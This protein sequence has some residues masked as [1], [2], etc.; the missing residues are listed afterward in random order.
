VCFAKSGVEL[1]SYEAS[2]VA[3][4]GEARQRAAELLRGAAAVRETKLAVEERNKLLRAMARGLG[5]TYGVA[6]VDLEAI[7]GE[8][9]GLMGRLVQ[10]EATLEQQKARGSGWVGACAQPCCLQNARTHAQ[11][12]QLCLHTQPQSADPAP[13][14]PSS[15]PSFTLPTLPTLQTTLAMQV[16]AS[17]AQ[18]Q[19]RI[20]AFEAR[21][22][23]AKPRGTPAGSAD[24]LMRQFEELQAQLAA[25]LS[26][27][28]FL[29]PI[30]CTSPRSARCAERSHDRPVRGCRHAIHA[31]SRTQSLRASLALLNHPPPSRVRLSSNHSVTRAQAE[32]TKREAAMFELPAPDFGLLDALQ[33]ELAATVAAWGLYRSFS[34]ERDALAGALWDAMR[35]Q[36]HRV[37]DFIA[38]WGRAC[39]QADGAD[40]ALK[41]TL[42]KELHSYKRCERVLAA[43]KGCA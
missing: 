15:H 22:T 5:V 38:R 3:E 27:A 36:L 2:S 19:G 16:A 34:E 11:R 31:C 37:D 42:L 12:S 6:E 25:L 39:E 13:Q 35:S 18:F 17:V 9:D 40:S 7:E 20:A 23:E 1:L 29:L 8:W 24:G 43:R 4:I 33:V 30:S 10:H 14:P 21:W 26:E 28:R 32:Q 41:L